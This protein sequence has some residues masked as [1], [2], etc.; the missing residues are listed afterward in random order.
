MNYLKGF[1]VVIVAFCCFISC[2]PNVLEAETPQP[3]T[4]NITEVADTRSTPGI[5]V[6]CSGSCVSQEEECSMTWD[7]KNNTIECACEGCTMVLTNAESTGGIVSDISMIGEY[8]VEFLET[9]YNSTNFNL[10]NVEIHRYENTETV[11]LDFTVLDTEDEGSIMYVLTYNDDGS[12]SENNPTLEINCSGGCGDGETDDK[13]KER[14]IISSGTAECTC[15][16][17]CKMTVK[18]IEK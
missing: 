11:L 6:K 9:T 12:L 8:F 3:L 5:N 13:C 2:Q 4:Q 14:Y 18:T 1:V 16:G 15:Q 10:S 17:S 7:L